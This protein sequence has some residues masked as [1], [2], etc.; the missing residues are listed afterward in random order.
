M[1]GQPSSTSPGPAAST[2]GAVTFDAAACTI[3]AHQAAAVD[4]EQSAVKEVARLRALGYPAYV[5]HLPSSPPVYKV[6]VGAFTDKATASAYSVSLKK[7]GVSGFL[8]SLALPSA[9]RTWRGSDAAYLGA[10]GKAA[11]ESGA[12][13]PAEAS[14]FGAYS[15][16]K[17]D[18]ATL[19]T[20]AD[21]WK[22]RLDSAGAG[23]TAA[24]PA[25]LTSLGGLVNEEMK[26]AKGAVE[27]LSAF[28]E[29]GTSDAYGQA[30]AAYMKLVDAYR[31]VLAWDGN[32]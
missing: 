17:I 26:A 20:R 32:R 22:Q 6:R 13:V 31:V 7:A 14:W 29:S 1:S 2:P 5:T 28:A 8:S 24:A 30:V 19:K 27:A 16:K 10:L 4:K 21:E 12:L 11:E 15:Q 25:D 23:L 9:H 3:Y 18:R